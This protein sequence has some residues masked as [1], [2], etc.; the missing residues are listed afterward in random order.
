MKNKKLD[1]FGIGCGLF[2][3]AVLI[4]NIVLGNINAEANR[5]K[6]PATAQT[7]ATS[8]QGIF[9]EVKVETIADADGVYSV[10]VV[11]HGLVLLLEIVFARVPRALRAKMLHFEANFRGKRAVERVV[12]LDDGVAGQC[13]LAKDVGVAKLLLGDG[14]LLPLIGVPEH[15]SPVASSGVER[16]AVVENHSFYRHFLLFTY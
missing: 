14:H 15:L 16:A 10:K 8:A 4:V 2:L 1:V 5:P 6:I 12:G 9:S 7:Y 11:E 3:V 13:A